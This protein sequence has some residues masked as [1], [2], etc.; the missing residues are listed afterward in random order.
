MLNSPALTMDSITPLK[1][2][3]A[4]GGIAMVQLMVLYIVELAV[5]K[6]AKESTF[7]ADWRR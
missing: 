4:Y 5:E 3:M 6:R 1:R 7:G 2:I